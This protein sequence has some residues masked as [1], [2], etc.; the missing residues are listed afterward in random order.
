MTRFICPDCGR[1]V[2]FVYI[3]DGEILGCEE[4]VDRAVSAPYEQNRELYEFDYWDYKEFMSPEEDVE[5]FDDEEEDTE[6][7]VDSLFT[8]EMEEYNRSRI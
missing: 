4:C 1:L 6:D 2:E 8:V 5:G 7:M 3:A